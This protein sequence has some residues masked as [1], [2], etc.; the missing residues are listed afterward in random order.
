LSGE[1]GVGE[2]QDVAD[3]ALALPV[4]SSH[5]EPP[6]VVGKIDHVGQTGPAIGQLGPMGGHPLGT[7]PSLGHPGVN[8]VVGDRI[9][10][11]V[12]VPGDRELCCEGGEAEEEQ[13]EFHWENWAAMR[14]PGG[15][16]PAAKARS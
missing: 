14:L 12:R 1:G 3:W 6:I 9:G 5:R 10:R 2:R 15:Y 8:P 4:P 11:I 13:E 7:N 16:V